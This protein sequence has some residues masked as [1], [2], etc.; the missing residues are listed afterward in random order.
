MEEWPEVWADD[1]GP[2][3]NASSNANEAWTVLVK[4]RTEDLQL[5]EEGG[6]F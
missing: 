2:S 1:A 3:A 6:C 4:L 5:V